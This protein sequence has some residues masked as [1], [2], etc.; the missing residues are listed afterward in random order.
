MIIKQDNSVR[1]PMILF[2]ESTKLSI[3][4]IKSKVKYFFIKVMKIKLFKV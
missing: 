4:K 1:L 2:Q 3:K